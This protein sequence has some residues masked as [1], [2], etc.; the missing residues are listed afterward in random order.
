[1]RHT[2]SKKNYRLIEKIAKDNA[3][4]VSAIKTNQQIKP[5]VNS[6][7][8]QEP[9]AISATEV[10]FLVF[11]LVSWFSLLNSF[12]GAF[13][14]SLLVTALLIMTIATLIILPTLTRKIHDAIDPAG[15]EVR[16]KR[17]EEKERLEKEKMKAFIE[18]TAYRSKNMT[19]QQFEAWCA[20]RLQALGWQVTTT[21]ASGD[22]GAD[23]II[24][25]ENISIAIQC[26]LYSK[27]VGNKAVQEVFAARHHYRTH[28]AA[29]IT[30]NSFTPAARQLAQSTG[31]YLFHVD[32][33]DKIDKTVWKFGS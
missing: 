3:K 10:L 16:N 27:P 33:L 8:P 9:K 28:I 1:M 4:A 2:P 13:K 23:L 21:K 30:N 29:V 26:K 18:S 6:V 24:K 31:V 15:I 32:E 12:T 22:Q 17:R 20:R 14:Y 7:T 5:Q 19:G 11:I 25:K